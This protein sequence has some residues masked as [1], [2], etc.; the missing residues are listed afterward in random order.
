MAVGQ[1][2]YMNVAKD[3]M[4]VMVYMKAEIGKIEVCSIYV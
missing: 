3:L 2:G 4:E 1:D